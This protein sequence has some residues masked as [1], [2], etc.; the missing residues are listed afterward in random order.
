MTNASADATWVINW[1]VRRN[2][3]VQV[4]L[5]NHIPGH[6]KHTKHWLCK[7]THKHV[8]INCTHL[9]KLLW[10]E[11]KIWALSSLLSVLKS[12]LSLPQHYIIFTQTLPLVGF[13]W[14]SENR[15]CN[16]CRPTSF[17]TMQ[18]LRMTGKLAIV[19]NVASH[20]VTFSCLTSRWPPVKHLHW[21]QPSWKMKSLSDFILYQ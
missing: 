15:K 20:K 2:T 5:Q 8:Y 1:T 18:G 14:K 7:H 19:H 17:Y 9:S 21:D 4:S 3:P 16:S 12:T 11:G 6:I 13:H 10:A